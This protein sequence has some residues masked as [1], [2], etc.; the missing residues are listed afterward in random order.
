M[1]TPYDVARQILQ[2]RNYTE[3]SMYGFVDLPRDVLTA[4]L[5]L[6]AEYRDVQEMEHLIKTG[7]DPHEMHEGFTVLEMLVQGHDGY[8]CGKD[9]VK[10][11]ENGVNM[12]AKYGVT[13]QGM[14]HPWI[15]SNC[16]E[17]IKNSEYLADFFNVPMPRVKVHYHVPRAENLTFTGKTF[18]TVEEAVKALPTLTPHKQY[19]GV[20]EDGGTVTRYLVSKGCGPMEVIQFETPAGWTEKQEMVSNLVNFVVADDEFPSLPCEGS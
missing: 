4:L 16:K 7:A 17:I 10:E 9:R 15:L 13:C 12:L 18:L 2:I 6:T 1:Y 20:I 8:W 11:V 14:K 19:I 5:R 3:V